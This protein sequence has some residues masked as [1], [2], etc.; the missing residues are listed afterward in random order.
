MDE[1]HPSRTSRARELRQTETSPEELFWQTVRG[2]AF[3]GLKFKRQRP[4]GRYFLDFFCEE[5]DLVIE[6][7]GV[8]HL[9]PVAVAHD[10]N[11]TAFLQ[12]RGLTV[13]RICNEELIYSPESLFARIERTVYALKAE[14]PVAK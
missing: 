5:L 4:F 6:L 12:S 9:D 7:D 13:V 10:D 1:H 3:L 2:R 11:R 14:R 8:G